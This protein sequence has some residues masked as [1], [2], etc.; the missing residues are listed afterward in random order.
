V[1]S[2]DTLSSSATLT[3][4][5]PTIGAGSNT[6]ITYGVTATETFGNLTGTPPTASFY[7]GGSIFTISGASPKVVVY[8]PLS[9][10]ISTYPTTPEEGKSFTITFKITNPT[11][12][13][14]T[15]VQFTL[16]VPSGL[17]LSSLT[18]ATVSSGTLSISPG[19]LGAHSSVEATAVA[20]ASSGIT[21]PFSNAKLTFAYGGTTISGLVPSASGI[22]ISEDITTRYLIPTA[23]I[24]LVLLFTAFYVRRKAGPTVPSSPK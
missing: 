22:A 19:D 18:N 11:G 2:F 20:V 17:G 14:V 8:Q 13:P 21:V 16:P 24:F 3:Q 23:F 5:S 15:G 6:T 12:V 9:V 7:F 1:D 10:T 4:S